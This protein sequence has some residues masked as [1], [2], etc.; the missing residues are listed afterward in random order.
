MLSPELQQ[1]FR[2]AENTDAKEFVFDFVMS[3]GLPNR[4]GFTVLV[5]GIETMNF[6]LNPAA[7]DM[8]DSLKRVIGRWRNLRIVDNK[9]IGTLLYNKNN[10][11]AM[12]LYEDAINGFSSTVSIGIIPLEFA[13]KETDGPLVL[14]RCEL[15]ECSPVNI[16]S[17]SGA[18]KLYDANYKELTS[19][20]LANLF[21]T[22]NKDEIMDYIKFAKELGIEL[23]EGSDEVALKLA[24]QSKLKE[25]DSKE[26]ETQPET[27]PED[28][29]ELEKLQHSVLEMQQTANKTR[30]ETLF[31]KHL[32]RHAVVEAERKYYIDNAL[33]DYQATKKHLEQLAVG[34]PEI[35][36]DAEKVDFIDLG[37]KLT[38]KRETN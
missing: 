31:E 35:K 36:L 10:P 28:T 17:D 21:I 34:K 29:S 16:P 3:S 7:L 11:R 5:S 23:P 6:M 33:Q 18:I 1:I 19:K 26:P 24:I 8:H 25:E 4:D 12:I 2:M 14:I 32:L 9:L 20:D 30:C 37:K 22:D 27:Q 13:V 38:W 15:I